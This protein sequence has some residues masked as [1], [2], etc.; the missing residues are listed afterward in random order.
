MPWVMH[1]FAEALIAAERGHPEHVRGEQREPNPC[2]K[3]LGESATADIFDE[4]VP[5]GLPVF[6]VRAYRR[7]A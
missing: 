1:H 2:V 7:G 5:F 3:Q 6:Q 4:S